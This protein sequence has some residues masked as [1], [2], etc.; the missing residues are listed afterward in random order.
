MADLGYEHFNE[1]ADFIIVT[2]TGINWIL[3]SYVSYLNSA[4]IIVSGIHMHKWLK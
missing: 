3:R 4:S 1:T 2:L